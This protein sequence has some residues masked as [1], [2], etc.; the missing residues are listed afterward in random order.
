MFVL[1]FRR[2]AAG[3]LGGFVGFLLFE[4]SSVFFEGLG[5]F[6]GLAGCVFEGFAFAFAL[7]C[8]QLGFFSS[9]LSS[10]RTVPGTYIALEFVNDFSVLNL[11]SSNLVNAFRGR[12]AECLCKWSRRNRS[13]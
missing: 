11:Y 12:N 7:F 13:A 5:V 4:F 8:L 10:D 3:C 2:F 1:F 6:F 9:C